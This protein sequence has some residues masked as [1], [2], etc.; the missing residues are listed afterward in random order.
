MD[1]EYLDK[2]AIEFTL[3]KKYLNEKQLQEIQMEPT[4]LRFDD[5]LGA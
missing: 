1:E 2:Y 5:P 4:V 3:N